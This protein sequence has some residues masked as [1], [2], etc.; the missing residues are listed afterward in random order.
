MVMGR[1]AA[2]AVLFAVLGAVAGCSGAAD[3]T[4]SGVAARRSAS[5]SF[6]GSLILQVFPQV[7]GGAAG[8]GAYD[9]TARR[10]AVQAEDLI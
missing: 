1:F 8:P 5:R 2:L 9:L 10:P 6:L 3:H 7:S 4:V